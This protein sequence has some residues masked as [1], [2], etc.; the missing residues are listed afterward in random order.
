MKTIKL[1]LCTLAVTALASCSVVKHGAYA[2]DRIQ[3]NIELSDL[4]FLGETEISVEYDTYIGIFSRIDKINGEPYDGKVY[5]TATIKGNTV[6]PRKLMRATPKILQDFP[7]AEY[8]MIT[9]QKMT[10]RNLFLGSERVLTAKV[11]AY[12]FK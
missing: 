12:K 2:P 4:V 9:N 5:E 7:E 10:K 8:F 3:M 1:L 6:L 11:K